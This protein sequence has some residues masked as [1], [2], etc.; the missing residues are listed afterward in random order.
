M[1]SQQQAAQ[2]NIK[3]SQSEKVRQDMK[4]AVV[5]LPAAQ[6]AETLRRPP[7]DK[8]KKRRR[9]QQQK[10]ICNLGPAADKKKERIFWR[11]LFPPLLFNSIAAKKD[12]AKNHQQ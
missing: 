7:I 6:L 2:S 1:S 9:I 10:S 12:L 8:G 4:Q 3:L 11:Q 5:L